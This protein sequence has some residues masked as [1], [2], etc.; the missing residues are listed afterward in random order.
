MVRLDPGKSLEGE[1]EMARFWADHERSSPIQ[2]IFEKSLADQWSKAGCTVDGAPYVLRSLLGR[3]D[4]DSPF[5][6]DSP[7]V[8]K[9]ASAFID[10]DCAGGRGISEA[11]IA[12]LKEIAA[13]APAPVPKL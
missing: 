6:K 4:G 1:E 13:K 2:G 9:L 11:E 8:P 7:D 5:A 12:K 3:L 10:K